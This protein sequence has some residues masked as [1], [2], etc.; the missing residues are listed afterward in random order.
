[1]KWFI[2]I[3][4]EMSRLTKIHP[5]CYQTKFQQNFPNNPFS[6]APLPPPSHHPP[7]PH[8]LQNSSEISCA[9]SIF[10]SSVKQH[11][12]LLTLLSFG[13]LLNGPCPMV[14]LASV[15][16]PFGLEPCAGD[17]TLVLGMRLLEDLGWHICSWIWMRLVGKE[18]EQLLHST[19]WSSPSVLISDL[20]AENCILCQRHQMPS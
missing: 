16:L 18:R 13:R 10:I 5:L 3:I 1:M 11:V 19:C 9:C 6:A 17:N 2:Q 20:L 15:G 14:V 7:L 12:I 4:N 8:T